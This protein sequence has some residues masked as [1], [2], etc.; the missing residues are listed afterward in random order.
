MSKRK[1]DN[2]SSASLDEN[3]LDAS[4]FTT[5]KESPGFLLWQL[6][7]S[8]QRRIRNELDQYGLTHSQFVLLAGIAWLNRLGS[9]ITQVEL[10]RHSQMDVVTTSQ[11]LRL[12]EKKGLVVRSE[13]REDSRA[14]SLSLTAEAE[15]LLGK[16]IG[17]VERA[18]HEFF[19]PLGKN[20]PEF[21]SSMARLIAAV[22]ESS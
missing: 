19:E 17:S 21:Q 6:S 22:S 3:A 10:A 8:W 12:L 4:S 2:S 13:H 11:T 1:S 9:G 7:N 5:P 20:L 15:A 14:K 16:A 18:D